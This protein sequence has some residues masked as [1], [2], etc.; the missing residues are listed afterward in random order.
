MCSSSPAHSACEIEGVY[1]HGLLYAYFCRE[2][3]ERQNKGLIH[4][5]YETYLPLKLIITILHIEI[6]RLR[7]AYAVFFDDASQM[8]PKGWF[9]C[10]FLFTQNS[11][12]T[13]TDRT[14]VQF[15]RLRCSVL[16]DICG[17]QKQLAASGD[18]Y[19]TSEVV[20]HVFVYTCSSKCLL[21]DVTHQSAS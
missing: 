16:L 13:G 3:C 18:A 8:L 12:V 7:L 4:F 11:S 1:F 15:S 2:A 9:Q 21:K 10:H 20:Q 19:S 5:K 14:R 6:A 17:G